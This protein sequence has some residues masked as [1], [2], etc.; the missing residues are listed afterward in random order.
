M[1]A[2]DRRRTPW[3][4]S[5]GEQNGVLPAESARSSEA[6][7]RS[8][9]SPTRPLSFKETRHPHARAKP[10]AGQPAFAIV[11]TSNT[12]ADS[13]CR[14]RVDLETKIAAL[15]ARRSKSSVCRASVER[16]W[17]G[18]MVTVVTGP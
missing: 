1:A 11:P 14:P 13:H 4:A 10:T 5:A 7:E 12:P 8:A 3:L 6:R 2:T 15:S 9:A 17:E 18:S 16:G